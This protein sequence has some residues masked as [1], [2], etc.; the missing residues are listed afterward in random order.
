MEHK[1]Y[2]N[3]LN[4]ASAWVK[5]RFTSFTIED[6]KN[7]YYGAGNA[8]PDNTAVFG[9]LIT[10]MRIDGLIFEHG[11]MKVRRPNNKM[12]VVTVWISR[13]FREKQSNNRK[14]DKESLTINFE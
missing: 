12:K 3:L 14:A 7:A 2:T 9:A 1:P 13:E 5:K 10:N 11:F 8:P 4:F 6:I